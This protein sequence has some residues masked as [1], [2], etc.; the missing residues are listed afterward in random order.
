MTRDTE[1]P[2]TINAQDKDGPDAWPA[3]VDALAPVILTR[4]RTKGQKCA[5]VSYEYDERRDTHYYAH[6]MRVFSLKVGYGRRKMKVESMR[7]RCDLCVVCGVSL[8][9]RCR[10]SDVWERC[11][12]KEDVVTGVE[13][14]MIRWFGR[15][16]GRMKVG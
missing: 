11:G 3:A 1:R 10:N 8:K 14:G 12:L 13:R 5:H 6:H 4:K 16:E 9:D 7:W 15:L 2:Q